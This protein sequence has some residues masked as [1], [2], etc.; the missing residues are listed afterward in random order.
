MVRTQVQMTEAQLG[1]LRQLSA[2][3][4]QSVAELVRLGI[5]LYLKSHAKPSREEQIARALE[6][7][8]M[9]SSGRSDISARHDDCLSEA[10]LGR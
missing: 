7:G 6:I 5:E 2:E 4:G 1:A 9:F 10:F 3:S 8:E